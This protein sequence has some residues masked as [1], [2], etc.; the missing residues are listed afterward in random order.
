MKIFAIFS[1]CCIQKALHKA[2]NNWLLMYHKAQTVLSTFISSMWGSVWMTMPSGEM[3][4][5]SYTTEPDE[6]KSDGDARRNVLEMLD[7]GNTVEISSILAVVT[8]LLSAHTSIKYTASFVKPTA[9]FLSHISDDYSDAIIRLLL[10]SYT[11]CSF[12]VSITFTTIAFEYV[13]CTALY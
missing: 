10:Q 5:I 6:S 13:D 1:R 2:L 4:L 12:V 8:L 11:K 7:W 3:L 9:W